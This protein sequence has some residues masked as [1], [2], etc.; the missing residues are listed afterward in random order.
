MRASERSAVTNGR[1][2]S[3]PMFSWKWKPWMVWMV[4]GTPAS[5]AAIRPMAPVIELCVCTMV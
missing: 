1:R 5:R 3:R 2:R 4:S